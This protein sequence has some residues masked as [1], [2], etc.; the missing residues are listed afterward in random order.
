VRESPIWPP[1]EG[2]KA[3]E[4][5]ILSKKRWLAWNRI[6]R[7][8]AFLCAKHYMQK[9]QHAKGDEKDKQPLQRPAC[10]LEQSRQA[11]AQRQ[12]AA[13]DRW[14]GHCRSLL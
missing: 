11:N 12:R 3:N 5:T 7:A 9:N 8:S 1:G 2:K 13:V 10:L 4:R 14:A 6:L